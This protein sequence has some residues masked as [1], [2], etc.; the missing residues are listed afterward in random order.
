[1]TLGEM[2][3]LLVAPE[4]VV[5]LVDHALSAL[6][7]ALFAEHPLLDD[8]L[9]AEDDPPVQ[10]RARILLRLA[11]RLHRALDAYRREVDDVLRELP[12]DDLP[13]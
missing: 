5:V 4:I 2:R 10:R 9:A 11:D 3:R 8:D 13:F 7:L 12:R 6:R 1:M